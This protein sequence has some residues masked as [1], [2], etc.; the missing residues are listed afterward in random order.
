MSKLWEDLKFSVDASS[1]YAFTIWITVLGDTT[2]DF[3]Y[4]LSIP[5]GATARWLQVGDF[6][7]PGSGAYLTADATTSIA[8]GCN[9]T[10][11]NLYYQVG[12]VDTGTTSGTATFQWA[13]EVSNIADTTLKKNSWL[14]FKKLN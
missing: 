5:S 13:Q 8:A 1:S 12:Y 6:Y 11:A 3:K 14:A 2:P 10:T 7:T 9:G 4:N